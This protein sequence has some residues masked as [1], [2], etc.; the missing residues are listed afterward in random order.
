MLKFET[1]RQFDAAFLLVK[2][3]RL[4]NAQSIAP[5]QISAT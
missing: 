2:A 1:P 4:V 3:L 5:A